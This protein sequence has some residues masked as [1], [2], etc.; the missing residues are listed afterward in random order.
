MD[1]EL[2]DALTCVDVVIQLSP[3]IST[4]LP[5]TASV[6]FRGLL[7]ERPRVVSHQCGHLLG[8][9]ACA[10]QSGGEGEWYVGESVSAV[11]SE[12]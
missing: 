9:Y 12:H 6:S 1:A 8:I 10:H 3:A 4:R 7:E 2:V 5:M 11:L